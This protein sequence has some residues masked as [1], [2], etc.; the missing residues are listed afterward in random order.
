VNVTLERPLVVIAARDER[1]MRALVPQYWESLS[2]IKPSS[3]FVNGA[4]AYYIALR[5]DAEVDAQLQNPY[6]A[7]YWSYSSLVIQ[8][9][10]G[11]RLPLWLANGLG[12]VLSHTIVKSNEVEF[13]KP[14]PWIAERAK[15]GP[16]LPLSDLFAVDRESPHYRNGSPRELYDAQTWSLVQFLIF[17]YKD[18]ASGRF[19]RLVERVIAGVPSTEALAAVYGSLEALEE[20]WLLYLHQNIYSYG[21]LPTNTAI[22]EEK[23]PARVASDAEHLASRAAFHVAMNRPVEAADLIAALRKTTAGSA[24]ADHVEAMQHDRDQRDDEARVLFAKAAE[25]GSSSFWTYYRLASLRAA[26]QMSPADQAAVVPWLERATALNPQFAPAWAFLA[27]VQANQR[28]VEAAVAS[29]VQA[30]RLEPG[31]GNHYVR[32]ARLL[33]SAGQLD[34][35]KTVAQQGLPFTTG[36][37]RAFLESLLA[38]ATN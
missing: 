8:R 14:Q 25:A 21:R 30:I 4:D 13:G 27:D 38:Q 10:L 18:D 1:S 16:R 17:G 32:L 9:S 6:V 31:A 12:A 34:D 36:Q 37:Q 28:N 15:E 5:A 2:A 22:V 20:A 7:A 3:V 26:G 29:A 23:L 33:A 19:D 11:G 24:A 35:A